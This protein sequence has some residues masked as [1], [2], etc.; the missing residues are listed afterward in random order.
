MITTK[1]QLTFLIIF[2]A[3]WNMLLPKNS[4][5]ERSD[6]VIRFIWICRLIGI[7]SI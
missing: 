1:V 7:V 3:S 2:F 6:P 5:M 4:I